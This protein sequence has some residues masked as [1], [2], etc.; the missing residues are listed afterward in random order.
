MEEECNVSFFKVNVIILYI[1]WF[2]SLSLLGLFNG[3]MC[4]TSHRLQKMKSLYLHYS[5][6]LIDKINR[7][8]QLKYHGTPMFTRHASKCS[9]SILRGDLRN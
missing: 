5:R 9:A 7:Q 8:W 3:R 4:C 2:L 6:Q 1:P